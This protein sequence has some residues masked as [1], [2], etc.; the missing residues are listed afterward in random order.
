MNIAEKI[1]NLQVDIARASGEHFRL[2]W[3]AGGTP[4]ERSALLRGLAE[5]EDGVVVD[6]GKILSSSFIEVPVSLRSASVEDCFT[7]CLGES[8]SALT[9]LDHLEILFEPSLRVNPVA[10]I[11]GASRH[12]VLVASWPGTTSTGHLFFGAADH[13][14]H[15]DMSEHE[16]ESV[17]HLL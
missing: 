14:S 1:A 11:K 7:A 8:P 15:M 2:V 10:L 9:C 5:A 13:P 4:S 12:A 3:L 6:V 16:L 17:L